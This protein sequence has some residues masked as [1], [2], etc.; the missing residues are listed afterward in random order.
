MK[1]SPSTVLF[2]VVGVILAGLI[3]LAVMRDQATAKYDSF[4]QCLTDKGAKMY[5]AWWCS[6]CE[7]QKRLFGSSFDKIDYVEC[8]PGGARSFTAQVCKDAGIEG[9][10]TWVFADG[11][12]L[13]GEQ[14]FQVLAD[15]T[16]CSDALP[17]E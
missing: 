2:L 13:G 17:K 5:G 9:T 7:A 6:H 8:S 3:G 11:S 14:T 1:I 10:P 4:A 15:K 12:R 16:E